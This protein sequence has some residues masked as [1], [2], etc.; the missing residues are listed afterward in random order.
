MTSKVVVS[1]HC[2]SSK[3]VV[4][5]LSSNTESEDFKLQN[6]ETKE[7]YIYDDREIS[8]KEV[9]KVSDA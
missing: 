2:A 6:N 1:A 4:I 3:E 5:T 9:E 8:V 7:L